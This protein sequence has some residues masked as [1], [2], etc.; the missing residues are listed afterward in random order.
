MKYTYLA[1]LFIFAAISFSVISCE[2]EDPCETEGLTYTNF[3]QDLLS[4]NCSNA[5][6]HGAGTTTTFE[7]SDYATTSAAVAFNRIVGSINHT[8]GFSAMPKG[9]TK[10]ADCDI[11][12]LTAWINDG[13]PE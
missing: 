6:C 12:K 8:D 4:S 11:D 10:L 1:F 5:A 9:G 7:M 13:A 3:A 2:T